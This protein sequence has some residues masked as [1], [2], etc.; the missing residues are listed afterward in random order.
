MLAAGNAEEAQ[1]R[2]MIFS[3]LDYLALRFLVVVI[4]ALFLLITGQTFAHA[5]SSGCDEVFAK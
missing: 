2:V 1:A 5:R 3:S 4:F